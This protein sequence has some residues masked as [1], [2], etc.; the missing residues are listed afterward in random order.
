ML[1]NVFGIL[2]EEIV[3]YLCAKWW[4]IYGGSF[5]ANKVQILQ[6]VI[7]TF[8]ALLLG[9]KN[10]NLSIKLIQTVYLYGIEIYKF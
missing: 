7:K 10:W 1:E 6:N 9:R 8:C 4:Q 3:N 2:C 5:C